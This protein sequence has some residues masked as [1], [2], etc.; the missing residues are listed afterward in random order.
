MLLRGHISSWNQRAKVRQI[1]STYD[2]F[3]ECLDNAFLAQ[4]EIRSLA[5]STMIYYYNIICNFGW[6]RWEKWYL[7]IICPWTG[8]DKAVRVLRLLGWLW[9]K[10]IFFLYPWYWQKFD[11][12]V[13][14]SG[15]PLKAIRHRHQLDYSSQLFFFCRSKVGVQGNSHAR[16]AWAYWFKRVLY[17]EVATVYVLTRLVTNVSQVSAFRSVVVFFAKW[18]SKVVT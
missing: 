12:S 5:H 14:P 2:E 15:S 11:V 8:T 17:Y 10:I 9:R 16:I 13:E 6:L 1:F 18:K 3:R 7:A 4:Y